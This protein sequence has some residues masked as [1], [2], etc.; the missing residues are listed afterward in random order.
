MEKGKTMFSNTLCKH[1]LKGSLIA[2]LGAAAIGLSSPAAQAQRVLFNNPNVVGGGFVFDFSDP[3]APNYTGGPIQTSGGFNGFRNNFV[4]VSQPYANRVVYAAPGTAANPYIRNRFTNGAIAQARQA[5]G[6]GLFLTGPGNLMF[7][8]VG[9]NQVFTQPNLLFPSV[10]TSVY[11]NGVLTGSRTLNGASLYFQGGN[12]LFTPLGQ[13][14]QN[15]F[16]S[17]N[18]LFPTVTGKGR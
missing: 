18:R 15:L 7:P 17:T 2:V 5:N 13:N 10:G 3:Y 6:A 11:V 4:S 14:G 16:T 1:R 8:N 12:Q 9:S